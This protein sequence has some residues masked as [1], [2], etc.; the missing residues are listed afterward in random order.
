MGTHVNLL[1]SN[2][3]CIE[4][5]KQEKSTLDS[6]V[7]IAHSYKC[8][9]GSKKE[10]AETLYIKILCWNFYTRVCQELNS[11]SINFCIN[12]NRER[13]FYSLFIVYGKKKLLFLGYWFF[14]CIIQQTHSSRLSLHFLLLGYRFV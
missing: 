6:R 4:K 14:F 7:W 5:L 8:D 10:L 1:Q 9:C 13:N 2:S 12:M 3:L 11:L